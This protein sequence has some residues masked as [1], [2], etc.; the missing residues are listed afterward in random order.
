MVLA[1]GLGTRM[2]P[3]TDSRPKPL[4]VLNGRTLLDRVLDRLAA[5]GIS[6][7]V[8]NVHHHAQQIISHLRERQ[9]PRIIISDER[10][11]LLDTGGGLVRAL[12]LLGA[13][14]FVIHN[15]DSVWIEEQR[16]NL[17]DLIAAFDPER[18]DS[19]MLLA[20][21]AASLGYDGAGDFAMDRQGRLRRRGGKETVPFAFTGVSIATRRM[22]EGAPLERLSLNRLWDASLASGRL[23]GLPL[24]GLWMHVGTPAALAEA[25]AALADRAAD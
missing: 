21:V 24:Q 1:A 3:L 19:L 17:D 10:D 15:S 14:P 9:A 2:R 8:V 12:P 20:P 22:F 5:A 4:V 13:E 23:Y 25:E 16:S 7:A 18:M 11:A 6:N